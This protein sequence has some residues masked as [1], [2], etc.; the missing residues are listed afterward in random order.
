MSDTKPNDEILTL[1]EQYATQ[2]RFY[3]KSYPK[4][5]F[6][7]SHNERDFIVEEI[8]L[9]PFSNTGEHR[10]LKVRKKNISTL[11]C[12]KLIAQALH[13]KEREIGYAGLKDKH[14]LTY[15]HISVPNKAFKAYENNLHKIDQIKILESCLHGNKIKIGHLQGNKFFIRLKKVTPQSFERLKEEALL[16]QK[17]G[18]PNFF[19]Y[20]RF[21]NFGDNYMQALQIK[22]PPNKQNPLEQ[23]FISSLQSVCFNLWLE[24]RLK[25]SNIMQSFSLKDSIQALSSMYNITMDR[26]IFEILHSQALPLTPLIGDV[27]MHYPHGKFFYFGDKRL[28]DIQEINYAKTILN[29]TERLKNGD[30]SITGLLSGME[31]KKI[32]DSKNYT[33][34]PTTHLDLTQKLESKTA[35]HIER[36]ETSIMEYKRD[37]IQHKESKNTQNRVR[38]AKQDACRIEKN[39]AYPIMANG[40]RRY[41]WV[42]P[43]DLNLKYNAEKAQ[44]EIAFTLPSGAYATSFLSYIKNGDVREF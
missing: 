38:L 39:F 24:E 37:S 34:N 44:A 22:K 16:A 14:A 35:C 8:P 12:V 36:S 17:H 33:L 5:P 18:F 10:I 28:N 40:A 9:Y 41:A 42:Y 21:G 32:L 6:V 2:K 30:I 23:L 7:F 25:I 11:E 29:D 4:I 27:C 15:Q 20:Q 19:G 3:G 43:T 26:E 31:C 13:I 1:L